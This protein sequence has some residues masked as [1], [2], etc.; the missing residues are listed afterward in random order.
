MLPA[1]SMYYEAP[2]RFVLANFHRYKF[3]VEYPWL[4]KFPPKL[5]HSMQNWILD[6]GVAVGAKPPS[7][8]SYL[9][10]IKKLRPG[11]A[12]A[13]DVIKDRRASLVSYEKLL[14]AIKQCKVQTNLMFPVQGS[15]I[16]DMHRCVDEIYKLGWSHGYGYIPLIGVPYRRFEVGT[17][18]DNAK[19]RA[20]FVNEVRKRYDNNQLGIH[21]LGVWDT[22]EVMI[23]RGLGVQSMD[24]SL[25][26]LFSTKYEL[27]GGI[28]MDRD[29][30]DGFNA[31]QSRYDD[32][33][34]RGLGDKIDELLQVNMDNFENVCLPI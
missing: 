22:S 4:K 6:C 17:A 23:A 28:W 8:L 5:F 13:L 12:V 24:S 29:P 30:K 9:A 3:L 15:S 1:V 27:G 18:L 10:A 34:K 26:L 33:V 14:V 32:L 25:C 7:M 31:A 2:L 16:P 20:K 11:I 21:Y 19:A